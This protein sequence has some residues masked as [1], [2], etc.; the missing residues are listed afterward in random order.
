M[1]AERLGKYVWMNEKTCDFLHVNE[2]YLDKDGN[3]MYKI[4]DKDCILIS[5]TGKEQYDIVCIATVSADKIVPAMMTVCEFQSK[6][7]K[8]RFIEK[9]SVITSDEA[10]GLF[11]ELSSLIGKRVK[12][13]IQEK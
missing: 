10:C 7:G 13:T 1:T 8:K 9:E 2:Q 6:A 12:I 5:A 11:K 3:R 4:N